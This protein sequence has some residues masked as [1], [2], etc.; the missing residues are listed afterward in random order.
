LAEAAEMKRILSP[1]TARRVSV[2]RLGSKELSPT[3]YE[4][5]L[6]EL[7][8]QTRKSPPACLLAWLPTE[9]FQ[10]LT[11]YCISSHW[12]TSGSLKLFSQLQ[13]HTSLVRS[14][15]IIPKKQILLT[16]SWDGTIREWNIRTGECC[17]TVESACTVSK[18]I[19]SLE[20]EGKLLIAGT[21]DA[22]LRWKYSE[23]AITPLPI[24]SIGPHGVIQVKLHQK[25]LY[26]ADFH[27]ISVW[28]AKTME[29]IKVLVDDADIPA[30]YPSSLQIDDEHVMCGGQSKDSV[31][32]INLWKVSTLE[33][34]KF[35]KTNVVV[36]SLEVSGKR[37]IGGTA[38]GEIQIWNMNSWEKIGVLSAH[39]DSV[40][41]LHSVGNLLVSAGDDKKVCVWDISTLNLLQTVSPPQVRHVW[42]AIRSVKLFRDQII[43]GSNPVTVWRL[44]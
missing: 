5:S 23:E 39:A 14:L 21:D 33:H 9:L 34:V 10:E 6:R 13:G 31:M 2:P 26:V 16:G 27:H 36:R 44:V 15:V 37:L 20:L 18:P 38:G 8:E 12:G 24:T 19:R 40:F 25:R 4:D 32:G 41:G 35:L 3:F 30:N 17:R 29:K 28:V 7:F 11:H 22:I 1:F 42:T 43:A